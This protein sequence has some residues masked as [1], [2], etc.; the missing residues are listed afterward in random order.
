MPTL[1]VVCV[2]HARIRRLPAS[3]VIGVKVGRDV[4]GIL[5]RGRLRFRR[6]SVQAE[7]RHITQGTVQTTVYRHGAF[8]PLFWAMRFVAGF[9]GLAA[10]DPMS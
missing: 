4:R 9:H 6:C 3:R 1:D 5:Q 7:H 2:A 8:F 10:A